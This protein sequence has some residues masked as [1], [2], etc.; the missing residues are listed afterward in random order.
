MQPGIRGPDLVGI[1]DLL[2]KHT[3]NFNVHVLTNW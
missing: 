2:M 1:L 3:D